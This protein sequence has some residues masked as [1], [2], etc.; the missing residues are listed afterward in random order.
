[1]AVPGFSDAPVAVA[2]AAAGPNLLLDLES[3]GKP[4]VAGTFMGPI[5]EVAFAGRAAIAAYAGRITIFNVMRSVVQR[6]G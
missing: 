3:D 2:I 4:R 5:G 6:K 1:M